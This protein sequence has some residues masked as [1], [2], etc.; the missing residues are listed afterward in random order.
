MLLLL[1]KFFFRLF[2]QGLATILQF[3]FALQRLQE[4]GMKREKVSQLVPR[5]G[6]SLHNTFHFRHEK[7]LHLLVSSN[8][9]NKAAAISCMF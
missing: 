8:H 3:I 2:L 9:P 4:V 6:A 1:L 7:G 5:L